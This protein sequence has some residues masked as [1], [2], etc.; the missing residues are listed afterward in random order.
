M[1]NKMKKVQ[2]EIKLSIG[3]DDNAP[4]LNKMRARAMMYE[5]IDVINAGED[6][7]VPNSCVSI[8][9]GVE[10]SD[11]MG[12]SM[13]AEDWSMSEKTDEIGDTRSIWSEESLGDGSREWKGREEV[14][15]KE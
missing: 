1:E 2:V 13:F 8:R 5:I 12:W 14:K 10:V 4:E 6:S 11:S 9:H 3:V 7:V 15:E